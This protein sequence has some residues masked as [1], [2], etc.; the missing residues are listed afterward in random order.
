MANEITVPLLPCHSINEVLE[1]YRA[2]GFEVPYHQA[3]PNNYAVVKWDDMEI[4][5]FTMKDYIPANSYSTCY[6]R[7]QDIDTLYK[8]FTSNLRKVYGRV[9]FASIPRVIPL[10]N[11]T[12]RRE[13]IIVDPGG[14]WIRIGQ[15]T[16]AQPD[17]EA[18]TDSTPKSQLSQATVA[19]AF[20]SDSKGDNEAAVKM[21]DKALAKNDDAPAAHRIKALV[22]RVILAITMEDGSLAKQLLSDIK[23]VSLEEEER[24]ALS[25]EFQK[26]ADLEQ[27]LG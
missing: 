12:G 11:K 23:Q 4:H 27:Q 18:T 20:L 15:V 5:F 19:A 6:V 26:A 24:E 25:E 16:E 17:D 22:Y 14:N 7:V 2:L 13:F 9:P 21:L 1:F 10:K 8:T 3:K